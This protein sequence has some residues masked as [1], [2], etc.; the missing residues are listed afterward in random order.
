MKVLYYGFDFCPGILGELKSMMGCEPVLWIR[1]VPGGDSFGVGNIV[2]VSDMLFHPASY[3]V[4]YNI[5]LDYYSSLSKKHFHAIAAQLGRIDSYTGNH[6]RYDEILVMF[7]QFCRICYDMLKKNAPDIFINST[8]PHEIFDSILKFMCDDFGIEHIN[9]MAFPYYYDKFHIVHDIKTDY[10]RIAGDPAVKEQ[11]DFSRMG[12]TSSDL[13]SHAKKLKKI[14]KRCSFS[15]K[16][17]FY[18]SN[19]VCERKYTRMA[20]Q[21]E[22]NFSDFKDK[23]YVYFPLHYQPEATTMTLGPVELENQLILIEEIRRKLPK[24]Y[25]ILVK[26][27][28]AQSFYYRP[29]AFFEELAKIENVALINHLEPSRLIVKDC[30]FAMTISGSVGWEALSAGKPVVFSGYPLYRFLPG[31][32]QYS[33]TLSIDD[34][35]SCIIDFSELS[36]KASQLLSV[37]Y[38]GI[39]DPEYCKPEDKMLAGTKENAISVANAIASFIAKKQIVKK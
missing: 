14:K 17:K 4:T 33:P 16:S 6:T 8:M 18:V 38:R 36:Y 15:I 7:Y 13:K 3:D 32:F 12:F 20:R 9:I 22:R 31:A 25:F 27:N 29:S 34:V 26:D 24:D 37:A 30:R 5:P 23:K 10:G 19:L 2:Y 21:L 1:A 11:F 39:V 35:L 28:P